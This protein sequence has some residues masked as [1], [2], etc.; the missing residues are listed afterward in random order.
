MKKHLFLAA[1][2]AFSVNMAW[3]AGNSNNSDTTNNYGGNTYNQPTANG[4]AGG[5]GIANAGAVAGAIAG[6]SATVKNTNLNLQ[7]QQQGQLQGQSQ[8]TENSNNAAQSTSVTVQGDTYKQERP[9]VN[10]AYAPTIFPTAPC[11]GSSSVGASGSLLSISGGTTWTSNECMIL[12]TARGFDQAGYK[13]D[14]LY[15][16]CQGKY[17]AEAPS[18]KAIKNGEAPV[19]AIVP[20]I[21][22]GDGFTKSNF[23]GVSF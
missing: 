2:L 5:T 1:A 6:A 18:C 11:M 23:L 14:G 16:R 21:P 17:A 3:A 19:A 8:S 4:G 20:A 15:I 10:T 7:G 9:V 13:V 12:E 22:D